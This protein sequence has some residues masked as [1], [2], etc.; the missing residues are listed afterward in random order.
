MSM[1]GGGEVGRNPYK[2]TGFQGAVAGAS[3]V[4]AKVQATAGS[5]LINLNK[6]KG[7]QT[8]KKSVI[9]S[10]KLNPNGLS[11]FRLVKPMGN[12]DVP[13]VSADAHWLPVITEDGKSIK[14]KVYC[15]SQFG[16]DRCPICELRDVLAAANDQA[17]IADAD[18]LRATNKW[19]AYIVN[20]D[21][22]AGA[23]DPEQAYDRKQDK[24]VLFD[25]MS[26]RIADDIIKHLGMRV[27][28]D[29]SDPDHGYD[30]EVEGTPSGK[31]FN[32]FKVSDY[33]L[34]P[35]PKDFSPPYDTNL[36]KGMKPLTEV[37]KYL[38]RPDLQK[39]LDPILVS[40]QQESEE[41]ASIISSFSDD[42]NL[43][44]RMIE[45]GVDAEDVVYDDSDGDEA[46][47]IEIESDRGDPD[48][49]R[50]ASP[51]E[52]DDEGDSEA[53][54][55]EIGEEDDADGED[56]EEDP[57]YGEGNE[58]P[59]KAAAPTVQQAKPTPATATN[60]P[61]R[62][63]SLLGELKNIGKKK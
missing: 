1:L 40:I 49:T 56:D 22:M 44:L 61:G 60:I 43:M 17:L 4:K 53:P 8:R 39:V 19:A 18:Q 58:E 24:I 35:I 50:K 11:R 26:S 25:N 62:T 20:R 13:M 2:R 41:A 54:D 23:E 36:L 57:G 33:T 55:D 37:I 63:S 29:A 38:P 32:N 16:F 27:W 48:A 21:Y 51:E 15:Y 28:G 6:L 45:A 34:S 30:F 7:L 52:P 47:P 9:E 10:Y 12:D 42:Y 46:D 59:V 31:M 14:R 3:N 5:G